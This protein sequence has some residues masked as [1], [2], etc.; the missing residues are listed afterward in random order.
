MT[1]RPDYA[2]DK[3][4]RLPRLPGMKSLAF[5]GALLTCVLVQAALAPV[6]SIKM[7]SLE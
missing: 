6:Y 4:G 7:K 5:V 2:V 3:V 1:N